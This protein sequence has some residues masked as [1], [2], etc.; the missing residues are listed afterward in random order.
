M[1]SL[2]WPN[3]VFTKTISN[4]IDITHAP[5]SHIISFTVIAGTGTLSLGIILHVAFGIN[6]DGDCVFDSILQNSF[7]VITKSFRL[8]Y[9]AS[10]QAS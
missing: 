5:L 4:K 3:Q 7:C 6:S 10:N 9:N 8:K 2:Q 1:Q